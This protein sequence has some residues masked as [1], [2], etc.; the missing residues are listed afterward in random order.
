MV[1]QK[2]GES[3]TQQVLQGAEDTLDTAAEIATKFAGATAAQAAVAIGICDVIAPVLTRSFDPRAVA[4]GIALRTA[5]RFR[6]AVRKR[7]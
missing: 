3:V 7:T 5:C 6:R 1:T 4:V 2:T